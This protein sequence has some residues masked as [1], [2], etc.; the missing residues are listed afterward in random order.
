[1]NSQDQSFAWSATP[2]RRGGNAHQLAH[3]PSVLGSASSHRRRSSDIGFASR[4]PQYRS[5]F[6][7]E[8]IIEESPREAGP[9][10]SMSS[11]YMQEWN[12]QEWRRLEH[13]FTTIRQELAREYQVDQ[14]DADEVDLNEVVGRFVDI[15]GE[16]R[17]LEGEWSW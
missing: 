15:Y 10:T 9:S 4:H 11:S 7:A 6:G 1:M 14:F 8:D 13:C 2:S 12:K 3:T 5:H 16:G 17:V